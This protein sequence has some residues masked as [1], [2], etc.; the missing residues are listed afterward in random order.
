LGL[1]GDELETTLDQAIQ[2]GL[3]MNLGLGERHRYTQQPAMTGFSHAHGHQNR[4][5]QHLVCLTRTPVARIQN[6]VWCLI[7]EMGAPS[8]QTESNSAVQS[9]KNHNLVDFSIL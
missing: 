9:Q 6:P 3:A 7:Q 2:K 5:V 4:C 1:A 8:P